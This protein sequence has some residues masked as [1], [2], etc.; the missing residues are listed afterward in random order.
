MQKDVAIKRLEAIDRE[1]VLL[2]HISGV[3]VW[4]QEVVPPSG[5]QERASQFGLLERKIY[6]LTASDE[7]GE[8]LTALGATDDNNEGDRSLDDRSRGI[9]RNY[10]RAWS[11]DRKLDGDFVQQFSE[12]TSEA[13]Q[14]WAHARKENDFSHYEGTLSSI[15]SMVRE[16]AERF[17]YVDDPYDALLD[18]FEPGTTTA[19][20]DTLFTEMKGNILKVLDTV[21]GSSDSVDDTFL[22][23]TYAQD[24]QASFGKE[25]LDAMGF[26]WSRGAS[27]IS[28]HPYTISLGADDIRIT[29]RYTEPSVTSPLFSTVHEGGHALYEMGSSN[30]LTRG[31]C[32]ANG[33]SLAFH[34]SQSRL[35]EN[36]IGRSKEFWSYFFPKLKSLFPIQLEGVD[37]SAFVRAINIVKPSYIRVDA[38]EVTYGLHII[39]RFE[40]ERKLLSG[41]L[42]VHELPEAWNAAMESL[43]GIRPKSDREGVLQ[44]VH[45]SMGEL[46]YFPT[47]ALGNLYGAQILHTMKQDIGF[48]E[49]VTSGDFTPIREW[50]DAKILRFGAMYKPKDL[51]LQVTGAPLDAQYFNDYITQKYVRGSL[52]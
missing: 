27:G 33:A 47:Y 38:D 48:E 35:W 21:R 2:S 36:M 30:E 40:L 4:D 3:L 16:K 44:D 8:I 29:T 15:I 5:A 32:L 13:H 43:L 28:T 34:E 46:G 9:I 11:R 25:V 7:M 42:E 23:T 49:I 39:L 12:L 6:E 19:E 50:L 37:L 17:G 1:V 52:I 10:Y 18:V 22:Y 14:V 24:K 26:D 20:V 31:T 45:W 41:E 51:L